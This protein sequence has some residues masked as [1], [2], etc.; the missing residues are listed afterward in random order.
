MQVN[1]NGKNEKDFYL[2]P[3]QAARKLRA[4]L[5]IGNAAYLYGVTGIGKTALVQDVLSRKQY[6]Y[7]RAAETDPE[8]IPKDSSKKERIVVIDDLHNVTLQEYQNSYAHLV[9][10][11]LKQEQAKL[12]LISRAPIPGWLLP[13]HVA[14]YFIE[15]AEQDFYFSRKEQDEYLERCGI[16]LGQEEAEKAWALGKGHPVSL[17]VLVL[18][19]GDIR[20]A[21]RTMWLWLESNVFD[22]WEKELGDFLMETSIV[23]AYTKELAGMIT[24]RENV[25][26]LIA[27]AEALGNFMTKRGQDGIWE[28]RWGMRQAMRQ[29]ILKKYSKEKIRRLY[30]HAGLYY[31]MHG[32]FQ[33]ALEMYEHCQ[34]T[35]SIRRVL[36]ANARRN[37]AAGAYFELRHYYLS[38]PEEIVR[39]DPVLL[40]YMSMLQSILMNEEESERWYGQLKEY[41]ERHNGGERRE[42]KRRLAYLDIALPHRGSADLVTLIKSAGNLITGQRT[43]LPEFS[44]TTNL[45][46][47]MNGGKDFCEWSKKDR[48]LAAGIGKV[49]ELVLGKYG[50]GLVSLALAE[51]SLE[52]GLD[53]YEVMRLAEKG[54]MQAES[55]GKTELCF[56]AAALVAWVAVLNGDA[57]HAEE[58]VAAFRK[59]AER[60]APRTLPNINAFLCRMYLYQRQPVKV[61]EWMEEAPEETVEFCT[62]ERFRYVTKARVYL[63]TGKY[64]AAVALLEKLS[65]YAEKMGRT[66]I[67]MEVSLLMAIALHRLG[68]EE[69]REIFQKCVTQAE[70]YHF[71]RLFSRECGAALNLLETEDLVWEDEEYKRQVLEECR[72]MAKAY[73]RYLALGAD[74][75]VLL[76][77]Q[78][79][80][81][82][83]LQATGASDREVSE[84]L[85]I[86]TETVRYHNKE[87]YRK[88]GVNS[89]TAA[90]SEARKRKLI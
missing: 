1:G 34:D 29:R 15:I 37:P 22:Q 54:R 89:R 45:P 35:E 33:E 3:K 71:V 13:I 9:G 28:Y 63:Q 39:K 36:A 32:I 44:V 8:Q 56:V 60:E 38:L 25:E 88:L 26:E 70:S 21:V 27:R 31:E 4:A 74:R 16:R 49:T 65:Y 61:M 67:K 84:R 51:S 76:S 64:E 12:I 66:Y 43:A 23:E 57:E 2:C 78:A 30:A 86:K 80:K 14:H 47:L 83:R 68:R 17:R 5:K 18:E 7:Y 52:K 40:S 48:E 50:K 24:G 55:G 19:N 58:I 77:E 69:W 79:V 59:R 62:L 6:E 53:S 72:R 75:E 10:H 11:L 81:I 41:A 82:L 90:V 87:T 20:L 85:G 46:S 42:A 73:P